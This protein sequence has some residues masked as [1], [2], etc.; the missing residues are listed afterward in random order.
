MTAREELKIIL[1]ET[2]CPF[3]TDEQLDYYLSKNADDINKTAYDCLIIKA[4]D[5]TVAISGL[6]VPDT[7]KYFLRLAQKYRPNNSGT[8]RA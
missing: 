2:A 5:T 8:L 3:F 6:T 4:E 1:R 7:S